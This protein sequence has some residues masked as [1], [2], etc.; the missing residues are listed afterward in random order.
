[1]FANVQLEI[2]ER[3]IKSEILA[4]ILL[5]VPWMY[6]L[7][8][9]GFCP[10]EPVYVNTSTSMICRSRLFFMNTP[11]PGDDPGDGRAAGRLVE[12][13]E[14]GFSRALSPQCD[15]C[16]RGYRGGRS[17]VSAVGWATWGAAKQGRRKR[18]SGKKGAKKG[19]AGMQRGFLLSAE[20]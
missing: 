19:G 1:M 4:T 5:C 16:A 8:R 6:E 14:R 3:G 17:G 12:L 9:V 18:R 20:P 15:G 13:G 10:R 11:D 7:G 2:G